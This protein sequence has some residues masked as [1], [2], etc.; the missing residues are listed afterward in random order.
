M[1]RTLTLRPL[2]LRPLIAENLNAENLNTENLNTGKLS[3][4]LSNKMPKTILRSWVY[5]T[6]ENLSA[7]KFCDEKY[8]AEKVWN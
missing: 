6:F 5:K 3:N 4:E 2:M 8:N 1:L 7:E